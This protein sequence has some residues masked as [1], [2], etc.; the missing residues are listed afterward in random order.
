MKRCHR[1]C[2]SRCAASVERNVP[3]SLGLLDSEIEG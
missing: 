2:A 1:G 3:R